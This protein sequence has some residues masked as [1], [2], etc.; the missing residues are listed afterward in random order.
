MLKE[1]RHAGAAPPS[2]R[3]MR[4]SS[5]LSSLYLINY[6]EVLLNLYLDLSS[7]QLLT[8]KSLQECPFYSS[9]PVSF[10]QFRAFF[11]RRIHKSKKE[12]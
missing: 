8:S 5:T 2:E 7:L 1:L 3:V 6:L 10:R 12:D 11:E 9:L 4:V